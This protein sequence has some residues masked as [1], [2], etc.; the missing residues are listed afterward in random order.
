[1]L[2]ALRLGFIFWMVCPFP[3]FMTAGENTFTVPKLRDSGATLG[4]W[5]FVS[6]VVRA[7]GAVCVTGPY[8]Y[9]RHP[10]YLNYMLAF[11]GVAVAFP[12]LKVV[13]VCAL[14]IGLSVYMAID[15]ERMLLA[16]PIAVNYRVYRGRVGMFVPRF[17]ER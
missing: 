1:M 15:D 3:Y 13:G 2:T 8:R 12:S 11:L 4:Y 10:F 17:R 5:P 6:D 14:D 9:V 7:L 16:S